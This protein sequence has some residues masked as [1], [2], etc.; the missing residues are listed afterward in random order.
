MHRDSI[1]ENPQASL[2]A[3]NRRLH[4]LRSTVLFSALATEAFANELLD[5]LLSAA[6]AAALDKLPTP[7]KLI[8]AT[9]AAT[10]TSPLSRGAQ[11]MQDLIE[12]FKTRNRLV[13][14]RP[15]GGLAAWIQDVQPADEAA[16]G[17]A[18]GPVPR[19]G[20]AYTPPRVYMN[21]SP[22]LASMIA[23]GCRVICSTPRVTWPTRSSAASGLGA[24][25]CSSCAGPGSPD[26]RVG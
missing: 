10:G 7:E 24:S 6:D 18:A 2:T 9:R 14:P 8:F 11:P 26:T 4:F 23:P 12:L 16:I 17:P 25:T 21:P 22:T 13:H 19:D 3:Q 5:E 15:K 1:F 20:T